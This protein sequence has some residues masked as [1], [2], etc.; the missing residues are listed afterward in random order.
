MNTGNP[1]RDYQYSHISLKIISSLPPMTLPTA[2][3]REILQHLLNQYCFLCLEP[4]WTSLQTKQEKRWLDYFKIPFVLASGIII[5]GSCNSSTWTLSLVSFP[6]V[7]VSSL[8]CGSLSPL[9]GL[10]SPAIRQTLKFI[11]NK[12]RA[13][14]T[15]QNTPVPLASF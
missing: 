5:S 3:N 11:W 14:I 6:V 10:N 12:P 15:H 1:S 4:V 13:L 8:V 2:R 7:L 9:S